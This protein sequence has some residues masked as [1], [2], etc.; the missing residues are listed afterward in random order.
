MEVD[1]PILVEKLLT[2]GF[3]KENQFDFSCASWQDVFLLVAAKP[4]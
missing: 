1:F 3:G 4:A 2:K